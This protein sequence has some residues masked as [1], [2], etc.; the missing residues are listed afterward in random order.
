MH[1]QAL[2]GN[3]ETSR[4][5][6]PELAC[7]RP[8]C[9][10]SVSDDSVLTHLALNS[11]EATVGIAACEIIWASFCGKKKVSGTPDAKLQS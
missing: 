7:M 3:M 4:S 6:K 5:F 1:T 2:T 10:P 9:A 11:H 8:A